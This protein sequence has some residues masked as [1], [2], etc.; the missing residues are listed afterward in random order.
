MFKK[1]KAFTIPEALAIIAVIAILAVI[2]WVAMAPSEGRATARDTKRVSEINAIRDALQLYYLDNKSFPVEE[3]GCYIEIDDPTDPHYCDTLK[4]ELIA[5]EYIEEI[6]KDPLFGQ[7][8]EPSDSIVYSYQYISTEEGDGYLLHSDL[9]TRD[10][11]EVGV[12][13]GGI[14]YNPPGGGGGSNCQGPSIP[15]LGV[16]TEWGGV[17]GPGIANSIAVDSKG[18][19]IVVGKSNAG[20]PDKFLVIKYN[21][22]GSELWS[23]TFNSSQGAEDLAIDS[24]D[25]IVVVG[26][27]YLLVKYSPEGS[28]IFN[29]NLNPGGYTDAKGVVVDSED[30]III[31]G[32]GGSSAEYYTIKCD[33]DGNELFTMEYNNPTWASAMSV[34]V[35]SEDNIIVGG[36]AWFGGGASYDQYVI[37]YDS[38]GSEIWSR[39]YDRGNADYGL[40]KV[41]ADMDDNIIMA[42][43]SYNPARK[44]WEAAVIKYDSLGNLLWDGFYSDG[45]NH[46][47]GMAV[48]VDSHCNI[49]TA[50]YEGSMFG[51]YD[52]Q[53]VSFD[54]EN[55]NV[56]WNKELDYGFNDEANGIAFSNKDDIFVTGFIV[57]SGNKIYTI[58]FH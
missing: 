48:A 23:R 41:A 56:L 46:S 49:V 8:K 43:S 31:T 32:F 47:Q 24:N 16:Q 11:H 13:G 10:P 4:E 3:E 57:D 36:Y 38:S 20:G 27:R 42:G 19:V 26:G 29:R 58:S 37:K 52:W 28:E 54:R 6:P 7:G 5:G 21:T 17:W 39:N 33:E 55:G 30:N 15:S 18:N 9:E 25:N 1:S 14:V 51:P 40:R 22:M 34:T 50:G 2:A 45:I 12:G 44:L 53:I 35:D